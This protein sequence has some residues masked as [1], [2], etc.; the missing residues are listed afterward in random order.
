MNW[1]EFISSIVGSLAWPACV[2]GVTF[3]V[4]AEIPQL[5]RSLRRLKYKDLELEFEKSFKEI[6]DK[7]KEAFPNSSEGVLILGQS[8]EEQEKRL[9][10]VSDLAPRSAIVEAWLLVESAAI[11]AVRKSGVAPLK[12]MPGPMRL[13]DYLVKAQLLNQEQ[14]AVFEKLRVL[15]NQAVHA[16][17]AEFSSSAVKNYVESALQMAIYLEE[18][19]DAL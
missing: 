11:D 8:Q 12:S 18:K 9:S 13:R 4:K 15:R 19:S 6:A 16:I 14:Q 17:D 5:I 2:I 10:Y 7:S 1:L 3:L